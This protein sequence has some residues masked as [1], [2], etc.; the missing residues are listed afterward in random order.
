MD[1]KH[2]SNS[3]AGIT[4]SDNDWPVIGKEMGFDQLP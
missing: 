1:T 3:P 2:C 4:G